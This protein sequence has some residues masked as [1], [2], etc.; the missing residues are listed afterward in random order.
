MP[1][2]NRRKFLD[3]LVKYK[4]ECLSTR[5]RRQQLHK[6]YFANFLSSRVHLSFQSLSTIFELCRRIQEKNFYFNDSAS[7]VEGIQFLK[8]SGNP[9]YTE[10]ITMDDVQ[11]FKRLEKQDTYEEADFLGRNLTYH[12]LSGWLGTLLPDK[13]V[14][15][16]S[17]HLKHSMSHLF[18]ERLLIYEEAPWDYFFRS[19][20]R[21]LITKET[22]KE[23][24]LRS[25]FLEDIN[26]YM[27]LHFPKYVSRS[28]YSEVDWNWI[29]Q[30]FHVFVFREMLHMDTI[31][32][33]SSEIS[34][35]L[36]ANAW[37]VPDGIDIY[38]PAKHL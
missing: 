16:T 29:T 9:K 13:F 31:R 23:F 27:N 3:C 6:F 20:E 18:D 37:E 35:E 1:Q 21:F 38:M 36:A 26:D 8:G 11:L 24:E 25:L 4:Y 17:V 15:V 34:P 10:A 19:Q 30:D 14:P 33:F 22:L 5:W 2:I 32:L 12:A 7:K 28:R